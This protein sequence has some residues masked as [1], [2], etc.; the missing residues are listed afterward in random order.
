[1]VPAPVDRPAICFAN[2]LDCK[3][4]TDR[5]AKQVARIYTG[6]EHRG[7]RAS[8]PVPLSRPRLRRDALPLRG[9]V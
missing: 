5:V 3:T 9:G 2:G 8:V 4:C 6:P 7:G 1:M